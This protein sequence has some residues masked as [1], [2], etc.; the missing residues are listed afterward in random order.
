MIERGNE[1]HRDI[2]CSSPVPAIWWVH[3][4]VHWYVVG[5]DSLRSRDESMDR[6]AAEQGFIGRVINAQT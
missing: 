6:M 5:E 1:N 3:T 2:T 4:W